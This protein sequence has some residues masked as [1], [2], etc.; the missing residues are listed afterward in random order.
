VGIF[1]SL[2]I[3]EPKRK[4]LEEMT[5]EDHWLNVEV[6]SNGDAGLSGANSDAEKNV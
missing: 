2:L 1:T 5:G 3:P 4:T 6:P